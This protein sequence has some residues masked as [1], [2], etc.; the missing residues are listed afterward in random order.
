MSRIPNTL[1]QHLL[2]EAEW[3]PTELARALVKLAA[4]QSLDLTCHYTKVQRWLNGTQP[5]PPFPVLLLEC[6]S[7]RLGRR[8]TVRE[9]G[10]TRAPGLLVDPL[11][12]AD[13]V[14]KLT[15]LVHAEIDP[16]QR[17]LLVADAYTL[18]SLP[19][20][21]PSSSL[22]F[23][24]A[25]EG[26]SQCQ[27]AAR[28]RGMVGVFAP[29]ADQHGGQHLRPAL[30]AYLVHNV[31]AHL[32]V[33]ADVEACADMLSASAQLTLLL[34]RMCADSGHDSA[35]QH[36]HQIAARLAADAGDRTTLAIALRTMATHAHN[37]GHHTPAVLHLAEQAD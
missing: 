34:G 18:T 21:P 26:R 24:G 32:R 16:T 2:Q 3:G 17:A 30:A 22:G 33:L 29:A 23:A 1:L 8:I 11:W 19:L 4:E 25:R 31:V 6:L 10:L 37:L 15:H 27:L 9:A 20:Q 13:P 36:Y 7:R 5:R 12:E 35:A 14:R 28:L